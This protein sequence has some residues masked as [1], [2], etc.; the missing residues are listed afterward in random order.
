M[1]KPILSFI[2]L[3]LSLLFAFFYVMSEF[4]MVQAHQENL[5]TLDDTIQKGEMVKKLIADTG[6]SLKAVDA[7]NL[8]RFDV[9]LPQTIDSLR[10]ANN[11]QHIG[12]AKGIVL[13]NIMVDQGA[14][15]T[16]SVS[17]TTKNTL[18]NN[19]VNTFSLERATKSKSE[20]TNIP[21]GVSGDKKY[22]TTKATFSLTASYGAFLIFL[23]D[24]EKSLGLINITALSFVPT[25]DA[26]VNGKK[27]NGLPLYQY[28]VEVETYSL[29]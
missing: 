6:E 2:V 13:E 26:S 9:F 16:P 1:I 3:I 12:Y 8:A 20:A 29:Q 5:V 18:G 21:G 23:G 4:G 17:A 19:V 27:G 10:F 11:L 14:K 15:N 7:D 22:K 24:L 25:K 28:T